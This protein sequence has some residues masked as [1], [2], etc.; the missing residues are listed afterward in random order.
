MV[1]GCH[2]QDGMSRA[3]RGGGVSSQRYLQT[4][5]SIPSGF[6]SCHDMEPSTLIALESHRVLNV[7]LLFLVHLCNS[8]SIHTC[9]G[10]SVLKYS[11][12]H[13][14]VPAKVNRTTG[15][16]KKTVKVNNTFLSMRWNNTRGTIARHAN[17]HTTAV[18]LSALTNQHGLRLIGKKR[19][20][21]THK[22]AHLATNSSAPCGRAPT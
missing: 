12:T 16:E 6:P 14:T 11:P 1:L 7:V 19:C 21:R 9:G 10:V 20:V 4:Q 15:A 5:H 2:D 13:Q 18:Y 8:C 17:T 22:P 3:R